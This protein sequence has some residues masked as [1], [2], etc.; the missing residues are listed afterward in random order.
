MSVYR[1]AP[2]FLLALPAVSGTVVLGTST[3]ALSLAIPTITVSTTA[4]SLSTSLAALGLVKLKTAALLAL[5]R[6]KRQADT[7]EVNS[8]RQEF[9]FQQV[10]K[11]EQSKC[12]QRFLCEVAT[13]KLTA[14]DF[15][16]AVKLLVAEDLEQLVESSEL[17]YSV[18]VKSGANS[19][20][21][22]KCQVT[23]SRS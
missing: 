9:L 21:I 20:S 6:S 2:L 12:V 14:P 8:I 17:N 13:T 15:V 18:A 4:A 1:L 11:L 3:A 5:R 7:E 19:Q 23:H 10:E 22:E 16:P